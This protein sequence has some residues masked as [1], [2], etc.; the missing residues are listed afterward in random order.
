MSFWKYKE[1]IIYIMLISSILNHASK[2]P[3]DKIKKIFY[4]KFPMWK[5]LEGSETQITLQ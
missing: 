4:S 3:F 5:T 2:T 1:R